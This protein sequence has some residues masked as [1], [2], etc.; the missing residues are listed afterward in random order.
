[1]YLFFYKRRFTLYP[2]PFLLTAKEMAERKPSLGCSV[3]Y[4]LALLETHVFIIHVR[5]LAMLKQYEQDKI[6]RANITELHNSARGDWLIA[7]IFR[8]MLFDLLRR[9]RLVTG[10]TKT[11]MRHGVWIIVL[12]LCLMLFDLLCRC[13]R[14]CCLARPCVLI[15]YFWFL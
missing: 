1:M 15:R 4:V 9:F 13:R 14:L 5:K 3:S 11:E 2:T 8:P 10:A 12:F 6:R 7:F